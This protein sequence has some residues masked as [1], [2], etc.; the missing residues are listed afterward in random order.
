MTEVINKISEAGIQRIDYRWGF[1]D[2]ALMSITR[3]IAPKPRK[4]LLALFDQPGFA[5]TAL[6]PMPDGVESFVELSISPNQLLDTIGE[7]GP[8]VKDQIDEFTET[9]E[10]TGK[11]D[12]QEGPAGTPRPADGSLR[13][14]R[15]VGHGH[16]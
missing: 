1:D 9:V 2:D 10:T 15:S 4:P 6:L 11:M 16:Q 3:I 8:S 13:G 5:R 7:L 14:T 12:L